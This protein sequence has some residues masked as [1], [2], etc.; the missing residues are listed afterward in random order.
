MSRDASVPKELDRCAPPSGTKPGTKHWLRL[1]GKPE[2]R[3]NYQRFW[4]GTGWSFVL[5]SSSGFESS[6][7]RM[8]AAGWRYSGP[9]EPGRC[10]PPDGTKA[11]TVH[12]LDDDKGALKAVWTGSDWHWL[13]EAY[14]MPPDLLDESGWRYIGP[15]ED[16]SDGR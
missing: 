4:T 3:G 12:W 14:P 15:V 5:K 2:R 9:V 13:N 16:A 6:P 8:G 1:D 10:E 11:G 7:D